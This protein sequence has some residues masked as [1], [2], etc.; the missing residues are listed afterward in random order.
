MPPLPLPYRTAPKRNATSIYPV[1]PL[2]P[3]QVRSSCS[4]SYTSFPLPYS[5]TCDMSDVRVSSPHLNDTALS[6]FLRHERA[7]ASLPDRSDAR[8]GEQTGNVEIACT[9]LHT[10]PFSKHMC[11]ALVGELVSSLACPYP[12]YSWTEPEPAS[13]PA[14]EPAPEA[15]HL[16][17]PCH[18]LAGTAVL[19]TGNTAPKTGEEKIRAARQEDKRRSV[20]NGS[21]LT[22]SAV[23]PCSAHPNPKHPG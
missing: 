22:P 15:K 2:L 17:H 5:R 4:P 18:Q 6:R 19:Q 20:S 12:T 8:C 21:L 14:S 9:V 1:D 11:P 7:Y 13:E 10:N 16:T 23:V 3:D